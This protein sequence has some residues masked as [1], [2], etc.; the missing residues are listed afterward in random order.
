MWLIDSQ[1]GN[2]AHPTIEMA[3][4]V[5]STLVYNNNN[6]AFHTNTSFVDS[7]MDPV[8]EFQTESTKGRELLILFPSLIR[9]TLS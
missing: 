1:L 4:V 2:G 3:M 8:F 9:P 5:D 6:N 7:G